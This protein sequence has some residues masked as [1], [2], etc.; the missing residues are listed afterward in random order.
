MSTSF[1]VYETQYEPKKRGREMTKPVIIQ[2]R[3]QGKLN[4]MIGEAFAK[5]VV[6]Q[7]R[8]YV[9]DAKLPYVAEGYREVKE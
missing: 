2:A 8:R 4:E 5:G 7:R 9:K 6:I 1:Y 3:T